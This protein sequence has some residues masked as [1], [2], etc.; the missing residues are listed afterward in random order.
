MQHAVL[1]GARPVKREVG[2]PGQMVVFNR[3]FVP[4]RCDQRQ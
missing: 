4:M 1:G 3:P 2:A